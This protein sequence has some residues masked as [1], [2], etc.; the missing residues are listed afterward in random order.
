MRLQNWLAA[1]S[2]RLAVRFCPLTACRKLPAVR[3]FQ[4]KNVDSAGC[5]RP[6]SDLEMYS[7]IAGGW[8]R[9]AGGSHS[10][11]LPAACFYCQPPTACCQ[12]CRNP[13]T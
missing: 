10:R 9:A 5:D 12:L 1:G 3:L 6:G 11:L 2:G 7:E 8:Q 13:D 4:R